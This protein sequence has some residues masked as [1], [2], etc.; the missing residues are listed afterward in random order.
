M[1]IWFTSDT[2]YHHRNLVR[3]LSTWG[4]MEDGSVNMETLIRETRDFSTLEEMNDTLVE[5]INRVVKPED[6]LFH[7][8]DWSL[9]N[10]NAIGEFREKL[11]CRKIN[12]ILGNHDKHLAGNKSDVQRH[13]NGVWVVWGMGWDKAKVNG[14]RMTLSHFPMTV[15]D[16]HHHGA[17]HL[18]GHS[19]GNL[20]LQNNRKILDVG[21]DNHPE[22]RPFHF[23]EVQEIMDKKIVEVVDHHT[24]ENANKS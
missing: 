17:W 16:K 9:G 2:H 20:K 5:N 11:H 23:D 4:N 1:N 22:F 8:G 14:Q 12:L 6:I 24:H 13:F 15:W 18:H 21:I 19:H 3:G 10:I 7:L